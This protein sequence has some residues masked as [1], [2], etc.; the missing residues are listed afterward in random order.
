MY[1]PKQEKY[2]SP[3]VEPYIL[4]I[5]VRWKE[6]HTKVIKFEHDYTP[7]TNMEEADF[8]LPTDMG[9]AWSAEQI[10]KKEALEIRLHGVS[11]E[12]DT[13]NI[14]AAAINWIVVMPLDGSEH[15]ELPK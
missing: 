15:K 11:L 4:V 12:D 7:D 8:T 14:P 10:A 6:G 5:G 9:R 3:A 2:W 1:L 13:L